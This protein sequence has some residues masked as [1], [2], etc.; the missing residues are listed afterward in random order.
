MAKQIKKSRRATGASRTWGGRFTDDTDA[1]A[2]AFTASLSFDLRLLPYEIRVSSAHARMLAACRIITAGQRDR[3]LK[4]L[5]SIQR[6]WQAG[7]FVPQ[8]SDEDVHMAVERRLVEKTGKAG[9]RLHAARSRNDLVVTEVRLFVK[10]AIADI[11]KAAARL[12]K[13]LVRVARKHPEAVLPG[14]THMQR[15]QPVLLGHHLL[16]YWD[17]LQRD[18]G[19]LND[20]L[21]RTDVL[22]LGAGA[23]AGTTLPIDPKRVA[24]DLGFSRTA[25][26]S[27]DAVSSRDFVAE[28][29]A[30]IAIMF[31][32]L[33]RLAT[34]I[35]LWVTSEFSFA[36]LDDRFSTGSSMMP[37]K[38]NPDIAELVR[39]KSGRTFGNLVAVLTAIKGLPLAYNSDLQEDKEPLFDSVDTATGALGAMASLVASLKFNEEAMREAASD[40]FL[41]ATDLAEYLVAAGLPFRRAHEITGRIVR[42]C[43][44][45]GISPTDLDTR[46]LRKFSPSFGDDAIAILNTDAAV[47]RRRSAGGTAGRNLK[48]RLARL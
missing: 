3:I 31:S 13:T 14:Y 44:D 26:N 40:G 2:Q 19:R 16:A 30:A 5:K 24:R 8:L 37:Q 25:T 9:E 39:G 17:M 46:A 45:N 6:E 27:M 12:Q 11:D 43:L 36:H 20:C 41:L 28:V 33:S 23:L 4:G 1:G 35:T 22:P 42:H 47:A 21:Q 34:D 29:L 15:A 32:G 48:K 18:R 7:R 38:R 10:D